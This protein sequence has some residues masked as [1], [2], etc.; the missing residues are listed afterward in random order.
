MP[1]VVQDAKPTPRKD[2]RV[3]GFR[4]N[5]VDGVSRPV[6]DSEHW[7]LYNFEMHARGCGSCSRPYY[8]H[9]SGQRLCDAGHRLAQEVAT[10]V[11]NLE[12][13]PYSTHKEEGRLVRV[14]IPHGYSQIKGLLKAMERSLRHRRQQD[15][16]VSMDGTYYVAPRPVERTWKGVKVEQPRK[17]EKASSTAATVDYPIRERKA[18]V[19]VS[20]RGSLYQADIVEQRRA[21]KSYNV[22]IREPPRRDREERRSSGYYR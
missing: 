12:G 1:T 17:P 6:S 2:D 20:K 19:D 7:A 21:Y 14:E 9:R 11:Y 5:P 16:F 8:V 13:I 15:P 4:F 10:F 18:T 22:E 3:V